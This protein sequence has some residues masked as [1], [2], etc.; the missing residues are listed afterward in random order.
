M[1]EIEHTMRLAA[2]KPGAI[3]HISFAFRDRSDQLRVLCRVVFQVGILDD[4][5]VPGDMSK[6]SAQSGAFTPVLRMIENANLTPGTPLPISLNRSRV[7]SLEQ[8]STIISSFSRGESMMRRTI[9]SIWLR[10]L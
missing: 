10:S 1:P 9:S 2:R 3:D 8:S 6:A 5:D 4:Y 7:P